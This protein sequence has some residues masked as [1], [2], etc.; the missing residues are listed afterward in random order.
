MMKF[1]F[2]VVCRLAAI[3]LCG[4]I[5][6]AQEGDLVPLDQS[7]NEGLLELLLITS[8]GDEVRDEPSVTVERLVQ[9]KPVAKWEGSR[10]M[11]LRYGTY[12]LHV[13]YSGAYPVDKT[14]KVEDRYQ[15]AFVCLLV[16]LPWKGNLV[17]GR[18]SEA[19]RKKGCRWVRLICPFADGE[20]A[21]TKASETGYFAL[22][23]V[24]PG[25]YLV[26]TIG[27]NGVCETSQTSILFGKQLYD[28][29]LP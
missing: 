23:N 21:E 3:V 4:T 25:K 7:G 1:P 19:S 6:I 8:F 28:L 20:I 26:F 22:Q 11:K 18:L 14:V 16:A 13:E 2:N 15:A 27:E 5:V 10:T 17:R 12:R 29:S 24:R 9:G